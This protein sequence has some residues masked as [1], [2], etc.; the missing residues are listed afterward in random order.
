MYQHI[1]ASQNKHNNPFNNLIEQS[2]TKFIV[3][4]KIYELPQ[5]KK[6]ISK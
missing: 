4:I 1:H 2:S 6:K 3:I 5:P